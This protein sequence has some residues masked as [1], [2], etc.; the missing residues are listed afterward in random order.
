MSLGVSLGKDRI[1]IVECRQASR[2]GLVKKKIAT[3]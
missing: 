3:H 1:D 2:I